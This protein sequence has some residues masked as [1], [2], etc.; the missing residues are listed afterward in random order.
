MS[1]QL[2]DGTVASLEDHRSS[3]DEAVL[4]LLN[5][6]IAEGNSYPQEHPLDLEGFRRYWLQHRA[7]VVRESTSVV[8][9][10]FLRPNHA[11]RCSH[12]ANAGFIVAPNRRGLGLGRLMGLAM[13]NL[14]SE[15]GF[16]AVQFNLVFANN[17]ASLKLWQSLGFEVVGRTPQAVRL[18][19]GEYVDAL[20]LYKHLQPV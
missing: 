8:A 20:I 11:G 2:L 18:S 10:F 9:A 17:L 13:L 3:D 14:A 5:G 19:D 7:F 16:E 4:T 6:V 1:A 15:T 12:I